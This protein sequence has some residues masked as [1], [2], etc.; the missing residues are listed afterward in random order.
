MYTLNHYAYCGMSMQLAEGD[1]DSVRIAAAKYLRRKR[2]QDY[3]VH[4]L[5][6]GTRWEICEPEDCMMVPDCCG[7]LRINVVEDSD[8]E[9]D[10]F[11]DFSDE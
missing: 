10:F 8:N 6:K 11:E 2:N 7:I 1:E 5:D 9:D 3:P 4:S